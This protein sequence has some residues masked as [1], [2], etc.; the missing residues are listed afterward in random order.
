[1]QVYIGNR[2]YIR[3]KARQDPDAEG[4]GSNR[5]RSRRRENE[6]NGGAAASRRTRRNSILNDNISTLSPVPETN[7]PEDENAFIFTITNSRGETR[8]ITPAD[9]AQR[10]QRD[11]RT[12][13][14]V[15]GNRSNRT[16]T[17]RRERDIK[18]TDA[19]KIGTDPP[20]SYDQAVIETRLN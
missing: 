12:V 6:A 15:S 13:A 14:V 11:R 17:N 4:G 2:L 1:M 3:H 9:Q 19:Q 7:E 18:L 10:D 20:P 8:P 16:A 5:R